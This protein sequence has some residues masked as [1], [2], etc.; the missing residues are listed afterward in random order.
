MLGSTRARSSGERRLTAKST[1]PSASAAST[2]ACDQ[3]RPAHGQGLLFVY[4]EVK[5]KLIV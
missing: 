2:S 5:A 1:P 3:R 4:A